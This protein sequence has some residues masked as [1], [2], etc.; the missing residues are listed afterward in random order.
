MNQVET[1]NITNQGEDKVQVYENDDAYLFEEGMSGEGSLEVGYKDAFKDNEKKIINQKELL[2]KFNTNLSQDDDQEQQN[3]EINE[4]NNND[5]NDMEEE[6]KNININNNN[7]SIQDKK[8]M[9]N[10]INSDLENEDG[11]DYE[12]EENQ[13][14]DILS[15]GENENDAV[16]NNNYMSTNKKKDKNN[17][18]NDVDIN[19]INNNMNQNENMNNNI[20]NQNEEIDEN[21]SDSVVPLVTLNFLSICQCCK[22]SFNSKENIPY[23]FK[24][25]H[26][27]CKQCIVEQFTDEEGIK[28]PNDGLIANS[29]SDL[30]ILNNFITDKSVTQR[31]SSPFLGQDRG[32]EE[33]KNKFNEKNINTDK[34]VTN[35]DY[36]INKDN[37]SNYPYKCCEFH[38]GQKLTHF[39]EETKEL[40]CVYCAFERFK[41]N[42]GI[43]IKEITDKCHDMESEMDSIIEENQYNIDIIQT[44]LKEIKKNKETEEKRII[45][46]FDRFIEMMKTKKDEFLSKIDNLFTNNTEKLSQKL[47]LFLN[48]IE[49]CES[50]KEKIGTFSNNQ[51]NGQFLQ[52]LE[53]Y[54]R[55]INELQ[56]VHSLKLSL[57]KYKFCYDDEMSISRMISKF[58][59]IKLSPKIFTFIGNLIKDEQD[60]NN[61]NNNFNNQKMG[62]IK[63]KL[64][65]DNIY[66]NNNYNNC[67]NTYETY[68]NIINDNIRIRE[69]VNMKNNSSTNFYKRPFS[70]ANTNNLTN[71]NNNNKKNN[72]NFNPNKYNIDYIGDNLN[73]ANSNSYN[74]TYN[75]MYNNKTKN[76]INYEK[77]GTTYVQKN[78]NNDSL[79]KTKNN[80]LNG[81]IKLNTPN[82]LSKMYTNCMNNNNLIIKN[83]FYDNS[84]NKKINKYKI[85]LSQVKNNRNS[86]T[87]N[88]KNS[89][90]LKYNTNVKIDNNK[91]KSY[92]FLGK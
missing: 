34:N 53:Y 47:E 6:N 5:N 48:K 31:T 72:N 73:P 3:E 60:L 38:K 24:C 11:G 61:Q 4:K 10:D 59:E 90:Q 67:Q 13:D 12:E 81:G 45:E 91:N 26:F 8:Y 89:L 68:N 39:I 21:D 9:I 29:I 54:N 76:N 92:S 84:L 46:I 7:N 2:N 63:V 79:S 32:S 52:L 1:N 64:R 87:K 14:N 49:K 70:L 57:Q 27:F 16:N 28:C 15:F 33:E 40:I 18:N 50:V 88:K 58:G 37:N 55:L 19:D 20:E 44:S 74:N 43:E 25:G 83:N 30:K 56:S 80:S 82:S 23:L 42:Q 71:T 85:N 36:K 75:N 86:K 77:Y 22:N 66:P 17:I 78:N 41:Q 69:D 51:D 62:G 35:N 65:N